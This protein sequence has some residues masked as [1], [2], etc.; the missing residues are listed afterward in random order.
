MGS[1]MKEKRQSNILILIITALIIAVLW[2]VAAHAKSNADIIDLPWPESEQ[3]KKP[4]PPAFVLPQQSRWG[5]LACHSNKKLSKF[6]NGH[7]VSLYIDSDIIGKSMHKQIACIDCHTDFSYESH[8]AKSAGG[9]RKVAGL[10]CMK[11]HPYQAYQYKNSIHGK[12]ALQNKLGKI[13]GKAAEPAL[14]SSCH[15]FH[16]IKSPRFEPYKSEYR[17]VGGKDICGK[18]HADRYASYSDSYHGEAYKVKAKDAPVCW[19]CHGNHKVVKKVKGVLSPIGA[20]QLPRTC[21]KCH[22][23]PTEN[24]TTYAPLIHDRDGEI[25]KNPIYGLLSIFIKRPEIKVEP[26]I[27][28]PI[29]QTDVVT[30]PKT[31]GLIARMIEFFFPKSLRVLQED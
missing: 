17:A 7:E 18:C 31:R 21:G 1:F 23:K 30:E 25:K 26:K 2:P 4:V 15:G 9:F 8:P 13:D 22:D 20:S 29:V 6:R 3:A 14:C 19:D 28:K 11:C 10:A 12:L 24:L 16:D 5:C 27:S